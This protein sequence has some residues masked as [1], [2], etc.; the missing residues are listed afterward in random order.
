MIIRFPQFQGF[1]KFAQIR[2]LA[3]HVSGIVA[4]VVAAG[5]LSGTALVVALAVLAVATSVGIYRAPNAPT[6]KS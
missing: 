6:P 3:V 5:V 2:K 1:P 4:A